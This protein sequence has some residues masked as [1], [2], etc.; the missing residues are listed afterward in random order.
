MD[1]VVHFEIP[2]DDRE[3]AR[4]FY[5]SAFDWQ[6]DE[7]DIGAHRDHGDP[8]GGCPLVL[9]DRRRDLRGPW[10]SGLKVRLMLVSRR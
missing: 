3:R 1:K 10:P 5:R 6:L 4:E 9:G 2:V 8:H 7:A